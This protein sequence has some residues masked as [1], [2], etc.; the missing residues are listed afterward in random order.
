VDFVGDG[1]ESVVTDAADDVECG[2]VVAVRDRAGE[3]V[4]FGTQV[5][6]SLVWGQV[7][8]G[9]DTNPFDGGRGR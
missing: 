4:T 6:V 7:C 3:L 5:D 1:G 2:R 8:V 9:H